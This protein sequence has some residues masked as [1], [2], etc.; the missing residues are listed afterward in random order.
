MLVVELQPD[1]QKIWPLA[2]AVSTEVR[3]GEHRVI[4]AS[5][6]PWHSPDF[7]ILHIMVNFLWFVTSGV[8]HSIVGRNKHK[9]IPHLLERDKCSSSKSWT[10]L[11]EGKLIHTHLSR[12][13]S[14]G[15]I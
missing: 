3:I 13:V 11:V 9:K 8:R 2:A 5:A 1:L 6:L 15:L 4:N 10:L 14:M 7:R 12:A